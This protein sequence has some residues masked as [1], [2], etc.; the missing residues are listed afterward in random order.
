MS[1]SPRT[2]KRPSTNDIAPR[3]RAFWTEGVL[4]HFRDFLGTMENPWN[5]D[6]PIILVELQGSYDYTI[7]DGYKIV[8]TD[9]VHALVS[10][11]ASR[12]LSQI[13]L[14]HFQAFQRLYEWRGRFAAGAVAAVTAFWETNSEH[15]PTPK[16]RADH[17]A[18]LLG[19]RLECLWGVIEDRRNDKG[20][21][22]K[23]RVYS[24]LITAL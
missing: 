17:V 3:H 11:L 5:T 4:P 6:D 12:L 24:S 13:N 22:V 10:L 1:M 7:N 9:H 18:F 19:P 23:V 21:I 16:H 8:P 2:R 14:N 15:Y 20:E